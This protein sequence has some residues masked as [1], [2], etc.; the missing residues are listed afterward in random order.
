[1]DWIANAMILPLLPA[2]A[3]EFDVTQ[4]QIS[5]LLSVY[6]GGTILGAVLV[7]FLTMRF[8]FRFAVMFSLLGSFFSLIYSALAPTYAHLLVSRLI[9]GFTGIS[10]LITQILEQPCVAQ[11]TA[12]PSLR[13]TSG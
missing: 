3:P 4:G 10:A 2:L 5:A 8:G 7:G 1:M 9:G 12:F 11:A 6:N 13:S